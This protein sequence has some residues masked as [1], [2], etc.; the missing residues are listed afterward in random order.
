MDMWREKAE[1]LGWRVAEEA[2]ETNYMQTIQR[3]KTNQ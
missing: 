2:S 1:A 3:V